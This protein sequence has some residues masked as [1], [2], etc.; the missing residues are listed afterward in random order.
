MQTTHSQS[1]VKTIGNSKTTGHSNQPESPASDKGVVVAGVRS[2]EASVLVRNSRYTFNLERAITTDGW[3]MT[4]LGKNGEP[5]AAEIEKILTTSRAQAVQ[6]ANLL[7]VLDGVHQL[8]KL[9]EA[10]GFVLNS[11]SQATPGGPVTV[12]F[13]RSFRGKADSVI[14]CSYTF[15]PA[16]DWLPVE[17]VEK[18]SSSDFSRSLS[19]NQKV[20]M[21]NGRYEANVKFILSSQRP[22][23]VSVTRKMLYVVE[24][25]DRIPDSEFTLP[26][27][28]IPEPVEFAARSTPMYV[29]L[30]GLAAG[31][32]VLTVGF[33]LLARRRAG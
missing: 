10:E 19:V 7:S 16:S 30:L 3:L 32:L 15:D 13:T 8:D 27:F 5:A 21:A 31:C 11:T 24:A 18:T 9:F 14:D 6:P 23:N 20:T 17:W 29:W 2:Q 1:S 12:K 4:K 26:A 25:V 22:E 28:G 33:R